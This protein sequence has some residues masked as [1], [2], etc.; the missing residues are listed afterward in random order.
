MGIF[1]ELEEG[2]VDGRILNTTR[3]VQSVSSIGSRVCFNRLGLRLFFI[4][5]LFIFVSI[6]SAYSQAYADLWRGNTKVLGDAYFS[7]EYPAQ[8]MEFSYKSPGVDYVLN[9]TGVGLPSKYNGVGVIAAVYVWRQSGKTEDEAVRSVLEQPNRASN[10][11]ISYVENFKGT[12]IKGKLIVSYFGRYF[13]KRNG[14][15]YDLVTYSEKR[16]QY[17]GFTMLVQ[18][19]KGDRDFAR[20]YKIQAYAEELF[21]HIVLKR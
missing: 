20:E 15:R 18:Y 7:M 12:N 9:L 10:A 3:S 14:I 19:A 17:Y 16:G 11:L 5:G 4:W 1:Y 6:Q 2:Q 21:N 13:G 8:W